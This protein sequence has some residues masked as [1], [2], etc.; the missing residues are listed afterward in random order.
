MKTII[1][2][3]VKDGI[4]INNQQFV[5]RK[6]TNLSEKQISINNENYLV[7]EILRHD[8][9]H[10]I[11]QVKVLNN[12]GSKEE[13]YASEPIPYTILRVNFFSLDFTS[14]LSD[15]NHEKHQKNEAASL[16]EEVEIY[17]KNKEIR[18][19]SI[20]EMPTEGHPVIHQVKPDQVRKKNSYF[21]YPLIHNGEKE[22]LKMLVYSL[23]SM[24]TTLSTELFQQK[25]GKD[26]IDIVLSIENGKLTAR[27][28]DLAKAVPSA[29]SIP[30]IQSHFVEDVPRNHYPQINTPPP[31][32]VMEWIEVEERIAVPIVDLGYSFGFVSFEFKFLPTGEKL[33]VKIPN[34]VIL[35]EFKYIAKYFCNIIRKETISASVRLS[36]K[37]DQYGK[38]HEGKVLSAS[39]SDITKI[40]HNV[41]LEAQKVYCVEHLFLIEE[42]SM[43]V[44]DLLGS[45][46]KNQEMRSAT[47]LIDV[48]I[49]KRT[50]CMHTL[51]LKYLAGEH[52]GQIQPLIIGREQ[53]ARTFLFLI[54]GQNSLYFVLEPINEK[55]AT[56]IWTC[57]ANVEE[58]ASK[59][60]EIESLVCSL[61][62]KKR[63]AY[64]KTK[65]EGFFSIWHKYSDETDDFLIWQQKL[66][67]IIG[68][69]RLKI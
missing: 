21:V 44:D 5:Q 52:L 48:V 6:K 58:I 29:R 49:E 43:S 14:L 17:F 25:L 7:A 27:S 33:S 39:S 46:I 57:P 3:I 9:A 15:D 41:V 26:T 10:K 22:L 19:I 37:K 63:L 42:K 59:T 11:I 45:A 28:P 65:S 30:E 16:N 56:Y 60:R 53:N 67:D 12:E 20:D 35:P 36:L 8:P 24:D 62:E 55:L 13:F 40:N 47:S 51:Q 64:R 38:I 31:P 1:I 50:D 32:L 69:N 2:K 18:E 61:D 4:F 68:N 23:A 54:R 66:F 34:Q